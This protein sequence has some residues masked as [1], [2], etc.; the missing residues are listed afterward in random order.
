MELCIVIHQSKK[1]FSGHTLCKKCLYS[2]LLWFL[3]SCMRT[4]Y[5]DIQS[6]SYQY[7]ELSLHIQSECGKLRTRITPNTDTSRNDRHW[8]REGS[9][10]NIYC[11]CKFHYR[12]DKKSKIMKSWHEMREIWLK[13]YIFKVTNLSFATNTSINMNFFIASIT[14]SILLNLRNW[15]IWLLEYLMLFNIFQLI[16]YR[17]IQFRNT[18]NKVTYIIIAAEEAVDSVQRGIIL[19]K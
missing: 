7:G 9:L 16:Y 14:W 17:N 15:K 19:P 3:F 2:E 11:V 13:T 4:E 1:P 12:N 8:R 6:E 5:G 10:L 18:G